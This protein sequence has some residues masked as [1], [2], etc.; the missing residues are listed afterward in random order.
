M[1]PKERCGFTMRESRFARAC[2]KI[3]KTEKPVAQIE[4]QRRTML[5][6]RTF[7]LLLFDD[8]PIA[9]ATNVPTY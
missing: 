9:K 7:V 6:A 5:G 3:R 2:C 1:E 8:I 4:C